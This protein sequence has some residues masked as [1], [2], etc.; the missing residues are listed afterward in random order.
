MLNFLPLVCNRVILRR[1]SPDDLAAFQ[2]YRHDEAVSR[3]QGW[4]PVSDQ[5]ARAFL[6][7]MQSAPLFARG[8]WTQLGIADRKTDTLIGDIGIGMSADDSR[9]E[10]GFSLAANA[11]RRGLAT[12]AVRA[13]LLMIFAHTSVASIA[14]ISDARNV[15]S[16]RLLE[17][18]EMR[19]VET[20]DTL[21]RGEPCVEYVYAIS[22][23]HH[24]KTEETEIAMHHIRAA[25][26]ADM[27]A[28][29]NIFAA[30]I[31]GAEWLPGPSRLQTDF[32]RVSAGE[33]QYV[34]TVGGK[35]GSG[36][37]L[38]FISVQP[39]ESFVHHLYV[40][41]DFCGQGV[42]RA[43]LTSLESWLPTPW[44]LKCVRTNHRALDF[45]AARGW[46][47]VGEGESADGAYAVLE[48][49]RSNLP[50]KASQKL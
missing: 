22:R 40:H 37:A 46:S 29:R 10:I 24:E 31:S 42:G 12:E 39:Q 21:F 45:Y 23:T 34:A 4:L 43:L 47:E 48:W 27:F 19:R 25:M 44:R 9:A 16:I 28:V 35:A 5:D 33:L 14:G 3:Y 41:P 13:A 32:A 6:E 30:C 50:A 11:Q 38:G 26:A 36:E 49:Q 20:K 15:A 18:L 2:A 17:H 7:D 1:L 8:A